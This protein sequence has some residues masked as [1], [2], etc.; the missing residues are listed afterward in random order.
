M[1]KVKTPKPQ[2]SPEAAAARE[3]AE[4]DAEERKVGEIR[5]GVTDETSR[6]LRRFGIRAASAGSPTAASS[7]NPAASSGQFAGFGDLFAG[8]DFGDLGRGFVVRGG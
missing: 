2:E 6:I 5:R 7:V 8:G 4:N 1:V 3:R